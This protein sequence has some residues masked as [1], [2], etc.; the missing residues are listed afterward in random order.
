MELH[1]SLGNT[2]V[3]PDLLVGE[4]LSHETNY[5]FLARGKSR[6]VLALGAEAMY[7]ES[8]I[9]LDDLGRQPK[10]AIAQGAKRWNEFLIYFRVQHKPI[11]PRQTLAVFTTQWLCSQYQQSRFRKTIPQG[12]FRRPTL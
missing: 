7:G 1:S 11:Y 10:L 6:L 5:L 12:S 2:Q 3:I 9:I 4:S 8:S